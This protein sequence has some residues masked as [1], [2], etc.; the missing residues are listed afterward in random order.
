M[1]NHKPFCF[2]VTLLV[3]VG[4]LNWGLVGLGG[5]L[6]NDLNVVH[7][8]LG[9]WMWLENLVYLLVGLAALFMGFFSLKYGSSCPCH[10]GQQSGGGM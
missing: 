6:G 7:L 2:L 5:F 4:G 3:F 10:E 1:C 9:T 8:L